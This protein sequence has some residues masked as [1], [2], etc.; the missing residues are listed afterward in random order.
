MRGKHAKKKSQN[1]ITGA[2]ILSVS[3]I[4]VKI[5]SACFRIPLTNLIGYDGMG[6]FN[7]AYTIYNFLITVAA[8]G[9]SVVV[10]K[11]ISESLALGRYRDVGSIM[12]SAYSTYIVIG[13]VGSVVVFFGADWIAALLNNTKA[14]PALRAVAPAIFLVS[15]VSAYKGY[16]QGHSNMTPTAVANLIE[17]LIKL[18]CGLGFAYYVQTQVADPQGE[19]LP[20]V[21]AAAVIGVTFGSFLA[22]VY[23][24][25]RY[26]SMKKQSA[27]EAPENALQDQA[28]PYRKILRRF[29]HLAIPITIGS[30]VSNLA[31]V[32]DLFLVMRRL[33]T[34]PGVTEEIANGLYG[35]YS[36]MATTIFNMPSSILLSIGISA[37][38]AISAAYTI[39]DERRL[40]LT[41]NSSL[42]M[43]TLLAFP[44]AVGMSVLAGP[45]LE[46]LYAD[47]A[48]TA[49]ATPLLAILGPAFLFMSLAQLSTPILQA[50]GR[51]D[52][53]VR[54]IVIISVVKIVLNYIL[55]AIPSIGI[56]GAAISNVVTYLILMI[57]NFAALYRVTKVKTDV[58]NV[59]VKPLLAALG[60]G[61]AAL[62]TYTLLNGM[63]RQGFATIF[64]ILAAV[65]VYAVLI[66][67]TKTLREEDIK[68]L[69]NSKKILKILEKRKWIG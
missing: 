49:I 15:L 34:L 43:C 39:R 36:S 5:I 17:V 68:F 6:Y 66:L 65:L 31:N 30:I 54:N 53:P 1:F 7:S 52:I 27:A 4:L 55:I 45:I 61:A 51:A 35:A 25:I 32:I 60:C 24:L 23:M 20:M 62:L 59:Y 8:A 40:T 26:R 19:D 50:V 13:V 21:V 3:G 56:K 29:I 48:G 67:F 47:R 9:L 58:K 28:T 11:M 16:T 46:L 18:F 14:A 37:L 22:L 57:L 10:A 41:V 63:I 38:P 69:P 33:C 2:V 44:C 12:K 42:K 64:A